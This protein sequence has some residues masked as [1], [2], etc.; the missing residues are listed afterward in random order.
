V[1]KT[2]RLETA[3]RQVTRSKQ[4]HEAVLLVE[5]TRG[6]Y[7]ESFSHA[8]KT[9]DA[10]V[11]AASIGKMCT[12][13][14]V[15]SLAEEGSLSLTDR[16]A[17]HLGAALMKGLH[18][19]QGVD[20]S[21]RLTLTDLLFQTSGLPDY[22][23]DKGGIV[24]RIEKEDFA[25]TTAD[26]VEL[27]KTM[28]AHFAPGGDRAYYSNINF[29][30]LGLVVEEVT[31][32]PLEQVF[33]STLFDPLGLS[34]TYMPVG[35]DFIP[36]NYFGDRLVDRP[37]ITRSLRGGGNTVTTTREL[38]VFLKAFFQGRFF[39][40]DRFQQLATYRKLQKLM[41]PLYY[42]GGHM[43]LP[44]RSAYT[45]F[46]GKGELLGHSG[47]TGSLAFY[48][49]HAGLFFAGDVNQWANPELPIRLMM[50]LAMAVR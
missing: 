50:R 22:E 7:S 44:L 39:P 28:P 10:P 41:G 9:I 46:Q 49:P 35:D 21:G 40:A 12:A 37:E 6:D 42:G 29:D 4:I 33:R 36:G 3:F 13:A 31:G 34:R 19:Y 1:D 32:R 20:Y 45:L 30:L 2:K 5:S 43:Q 11:Q 25:M 14:C 18:V 26:I 48:Y 16:L 23:Y 8:G 38:M 17:D 24:P 15:L 27:T 47:S